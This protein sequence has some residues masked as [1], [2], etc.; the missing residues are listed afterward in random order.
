MALQFNPATPTQQ[1]I[2]TQNQFAQPQQNLQ[3]FQQ[4]VI[5]ALPAKITGTRNPL[6]VA[7]FETKLK[8]VSDCALSIGASYSSPAKSSEVPVHA[9]DT[10]EWRALARQIMGY[11]PEYAACLKTYT[12]A[13]T[14]KAKRDPNSGLVFIDARL[15]K[16]FTDAGIFIQA[17][18]HDEKGV[19]THEAGTFSFPIDEDCGGVAITTRQLAASAMVALVDHYN[20][21]KDGYIR[22][23]IPELSAMFSS[24]LIE[25]VAN[26]PPKEKKV[27]KTPKPQTAAKTKKVKKAPLIYVPVLDP[28]TGT[29]I[30]PPQSTPHIVSSMLS[31]LVDCYILS[32][33]PRNVGE[34]VLAELQAARMCLT[35]KTILRNT[36]KKAT[37]KNARIQ[38]K[39]EKV[40]NNL[41]PNNVQTLQ[42]NPDFHIDSTGQDGIGQYVPAPTASF[43]QAAPNQ[44]AFNQNSHVQ[45]AG[46]TPL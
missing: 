41:A 12:E 34:R 24:Q 6:S 8:L 9:P 2:P 40:T 19:V 36:R 42:I 30:V 45:F 29:P 11:G 25:Y 23:D 43:T 15:Q 38:A 28:S 32:L 35:H 17:L 3:Q 16:L 10:A 37:E 26:K 20:L 46:A 39:V 27:P 18:E 21:K 13:I 22:F 33:R 44:Q 31:S 1:Q 14:K 5:P 4:Q 7:D